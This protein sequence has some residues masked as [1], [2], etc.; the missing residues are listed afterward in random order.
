[1]P[2]TFAVAGVQVWFY[3]DGSQFQFG[4]FA[5]NTLSFLK[6]EFA[7]EYRRSIRQ[8]TTESHRRKAQLGHHIGGRRFGYRNI[9]V[10]KHKDLAIHPD[11]APVVARIFT[12]R[13]SGTG[14]TRIAKTLNREHAPCPRPQQGR[15]AGWAPTTVRAILHNELY[16]GVV[17]TFRTEEA[18][19]KRGREPDA[20]AAVGVGAHRP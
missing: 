8:K 19:C 17:V 5:S 4:D 3:A 9:T 20:P 15:P 13:A 14:Y 2:G 10:E 1:M 7:A 12:L 16:R 11:E 18:R 6:A